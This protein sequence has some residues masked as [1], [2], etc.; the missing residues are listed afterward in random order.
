M[1]TTMKR[2]VF[3][4]ATLFLL[5]WMMTEPDPQSTNE[6]LVMSV[7]WF[8]TSAEMRA[9][10]YQTFYFAKTQLDADRQVQKKGDR[11]RAVVV[12]VDETVLDNSPHSA[13]TILENKSFPYGWS[14]WVNRANAEALPG[15]VEFMNYAVEKGYDVFYVSNRTAKDEL[16]GTMT[17]LRDRGFPQAD[18]SHIL[19]RTTESSKEGRRELIRKTHDIVLLLGDNLNDLDLAFERKATD[20]R[21]KEVD[22]LKAEFGPR[23]IVL[24]NPMYGEWESAAYKYQRGLSDDEKGRMRRAALKS[25]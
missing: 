23:Y 6:H 22:R 16:A 11:R 10:S 15:A 7:L 24:P 3:P 2:F 4:F 5:G 19:L 18:S 20:D 25:F 21:F 17:N 1:K 14:E 9:L 12:D 13:K 8:Q